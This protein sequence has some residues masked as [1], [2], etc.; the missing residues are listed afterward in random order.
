MK[1]TPQKKPGKKGEP[2]QLENISDF[3]KHKFDNMLAPQPNGCIF[4][5]GNVQN[6]GYINWWYR[7][8]DQDGEPN[9]R[10]I[11]AHRFSALVSGKFNIDDL[12]ELCVLHDCDQNYAKTDISYRQCVNPDHLWLGTAKDNIRDCMK[13]GRYVKPPT[14]YGA[15]NKNS[16]LT[17][18]QAQ[19]VIEKHYHITQK[20][21][22]EI[23]KVNQS[24]IEAIHMNKTWCHLPR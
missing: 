20:R 10:F 7:H 11:T 22:A 12:N 4:H 16:K 6:N 9:L 19:W 21:L 5:T 15:D 14:L 2:H 23:L 3:Y 17:E 24:T 18:D 13:K 8:K 1:K